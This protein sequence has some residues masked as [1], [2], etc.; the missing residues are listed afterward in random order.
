LKLNTDLAPDADG[1]VERFKARDSNSI[2]FKYNFINGLY[3][4][5]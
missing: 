2:P 5:I 4:S 3:H 1:Y